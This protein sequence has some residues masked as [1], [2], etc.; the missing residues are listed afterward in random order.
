MQTVFPILRYEDARAAIEWLSR[1]FGFVSS[2][3]VPEEGPVVRHAQL[4]LGTNVI[5]LGSLREGDG[6]STP[7]LA[8]CATQA[9]CVYVP[10]PDAHFARA[11][12][13]GAEVIQAPSDTDFGAR[14]YHVR[15]P[16]GHTWT[17]TDYRPALEDRAGRRDPTEADAPMHTH[18]AIDY[19]ELTVRDLGEAKSFYERAF[20]WRFN[21]YGPEYAGI[22]GAERELGGLRQTT[23]LRQ[24]GPLVVLYST[25]LESSLAA[26][27]AAGG[28]VVT[29]PFSFPG[30]RR[31]HFAD[32]SGN[33]LAV[34]SP[35]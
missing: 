11:R 5:M 2:F 8:G 33:E 17:F 20:A 34:W 13:A 25:D 9:L 1:A 26:V 21:D 31:F 18:H 23:E 27:E 22:Q 29:P 30:G 15:D 4:R 14:E 28:R 7:R 35:A 16:E 3:A 19:V 6:M 10:D 12:A 24:G 32:P